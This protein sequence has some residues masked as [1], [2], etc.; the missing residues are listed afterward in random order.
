MA[1]LDAY[2][3]QAATGT[4]STQLI[5]YIGPTIFPVRGV[6]LGAYAEISQTDIKV[7]GTATQAVNG[8]INWFFYPHFELVIQARLQSPQ[9]EEAAET[10]MAQLHLFL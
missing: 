6:W 9:Q 2:Q 3:V 8:Q 10:F 1:Q 5:G 7:K 4:A